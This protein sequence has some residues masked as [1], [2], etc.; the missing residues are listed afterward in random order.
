MGKFRIKY[1]NWS[2]QEVT[3]EVDGDTEEKAL[4]NFYGSSDNLWCQRKLALERVKDEEP[5]PVKGR[6]VRRGGN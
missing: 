6:R 4:M 3:K 1:L 5:E 2:N